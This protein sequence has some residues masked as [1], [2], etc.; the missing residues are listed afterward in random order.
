MVVGRLS[1]MTSMPLI[2]TRTL[3]SRT[4]PSATLVNAAG[5]VML[6][7][8]RYQVVIGLFAVSAVAEYRALVSVAVTKLCPA[9]FP[10]GIVERFRCPV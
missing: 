9:S 5:E 2:K 3:S 8:A 6:T 1:R 7:F 4:T 10:A